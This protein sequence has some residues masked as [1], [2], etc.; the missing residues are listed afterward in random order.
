MAVLKQAEDCP[1]FRHCADGTAS[2]AP[3]F[4]NWRDETGGPNTAARLPRQR[5]GSESGNPAIARQS[6]T[7]DPG[8]FGQPGGIISSSIDGGNRGNY[9]TKRAR[10]IA[11]AHIGDIPAIQLFRR[12]PRVQVKGMRKA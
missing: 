3:A 6:R 10:D 7:S 4:C 2:V 5:P 9:R 12:T 8:D 1:R 11:E